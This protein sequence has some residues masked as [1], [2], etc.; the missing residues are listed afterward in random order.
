MQ[1]NSIPYYPVYTEASTSK[2]LICPPK[3]TDTS[4]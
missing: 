3:N 4:M 1:G 2:N